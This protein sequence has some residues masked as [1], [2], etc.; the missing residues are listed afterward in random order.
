MYG[1]NHH[2]TV[3]YPPIKNK[4]IK[5]KVFDSFY[6]VR[7]KKNHIINIYFVQGFKRVES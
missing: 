1:K 7:Q 3:N 4:H 6:M 5:K 2:N